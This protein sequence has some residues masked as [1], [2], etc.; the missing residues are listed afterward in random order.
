MS[1]FNLIV[2]TLFDIALIAVYCLGL[3]I[4]LGIYIGHPSGAG[5]VPLWAGLVTAAFW[6]VALVYIL[7]T[8]D[9]CSGK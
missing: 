1:M 7:A 8:W 5:K 4:H 9:R 3:G 2:V 6:P